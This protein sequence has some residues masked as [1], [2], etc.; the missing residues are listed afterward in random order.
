[1]YNDCIQKMYKH[2]R[3]EGGSQAESIARSL[4]CGINK[5]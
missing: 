3:G 4:T 5:I 2:Y 1:M